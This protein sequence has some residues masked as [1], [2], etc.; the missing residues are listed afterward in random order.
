MWKVYFA[1]TET[2]LFPV[3]QILYTLVMTPFVKVGKTDGPFKIFQ[4]TFIQYKKTKVLKV[5][6]CE[7]NL[8]QQ[9]VSFPLSANVKW[10]LIM[11]ILFITFSSKFASKCFISSFT[12]TG[13]CTK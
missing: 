7:C 1:E 10:G 3:L 4:L 2:T 5:H 13:M 11:D 8:E 6:Y 9:R 12:S